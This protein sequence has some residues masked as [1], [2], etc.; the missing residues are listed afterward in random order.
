[1]NMELLST[2]LEWSGGMGDILGALIL[3]RKTEN[4]GYAYPVFIGSSLCL[5]L[6][7]LINAH[8]GLLTAQAVFMAINGYGAYRW[9][10]W[11][12]RPEEPNEPV[13]RGFAVGR[14]YR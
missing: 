12:P 8:W 5:M 14:E 13:D 4:S 10:I 1:M 6:F 7:A 11:R 2:V 3:A 9:L